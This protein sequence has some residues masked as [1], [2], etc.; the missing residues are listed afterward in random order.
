M[1]SKEMG[2]NKKEEKKITISVDEDGLAAYIHLL[3]M[4]ENKQYTKQDIL[5]AL[6]ENGVME[7]I[8]EDAIERV[9]KN[10]IYNEYICVAKGTPK[11]DGKDGYYECLFDTKKDNKPKELPDGS[12]DYSSIGDV[13]V[14]EEGVEIVL[15]H[16]ATKG[17][18]GITVKG[19]SIIAKPGKDRSPLKG[20]GF[21]ISEDKLRYRTALTGRVTYEEGKLEVSNLFFVDSDVN[22]LT[23]NIDFAGDI[24]VKGN[25]TTGMRVRAL[26]NIS[27]DGHVEG[28]EL[29]AGKDVVLKNGM[30]GA[31]K[32]S[33]KA[34]G[35]VSGKFF[36]QVD[37]SALGNIKA[38]AILNSVVEAGKSICVQ[39]R[40]GAIIGGRA[41]ALEKID[42]TI[43]GS[44]SEVKTE[45]MVGIDC[46]LQAEL[47]KIDGNIKE[48]ED[49]LKKIQMVLEQM[50][51]VLSKKPSKELL[52]KK[53]KFKRVERDKIKMINNLKESRQ[54]IV[55]KVEKTLRSKILVQ[56]TIHAGT[57]VRVNSNV[58]L[59]KDNSNYNVI[60]KQRENEI[61]II[62]NI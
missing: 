24:V 58:M 22:Y 28:A 36:E 53:I 32:G 50:E 57:I 30:Q 31:G 26:G 48:Q 40:R 12:V 2:D 56:K 41:R 44:M 62:P 7:G 9:L 16:P 20:K 4:L 45:L 33:V 23:G 47:L 5:N 13:E 15:Y 38:N 3:P 25:V 59:I 21:L 10:N 52:E 17:R 14:I 61:C 34:G 42:V 37:I 29:I 55:I 46:N 60:I 8:E 19:T 1:V 43:V 54:N 35:D 6:T 27:I 49:E 11:Q 39:G 18:D 51:Q